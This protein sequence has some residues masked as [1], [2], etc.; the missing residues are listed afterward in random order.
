MRE[1][2]AQGVIFQY[3]RFIGITVWDGYKLRTYRVPL[4]GQRMRE[5]CPTN[6]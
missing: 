5:G 4:P 6:G 3:W 1:P 2:Y